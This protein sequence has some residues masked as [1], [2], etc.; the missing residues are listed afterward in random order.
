MPL[1]ADPSAFVAAAE[2]GINSRDLDAT[3]G[4]YAANARLESVTDGAVETH[5]GAEAI[6][7]AWKG[8]LEAMGERGFRLSKKL[9]AASG[10]TIV[11]EWTGTLGGRTRAEGLELW[12]FDGEG[13]VYEHRMLSFLNLKPSTSPL[14]RLRI[15]LAYPLTAVAFLRAGRRAARDGGGRSGG[16]GGG[17]RAGGAG[18]EAG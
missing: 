17:G 11:N 7:R 15:G 10:D 4:V 5:Q 8:Y 3:A 1:P 2:A 9:T 16:A 6:R 12:R 18:G 14:Q 13:K